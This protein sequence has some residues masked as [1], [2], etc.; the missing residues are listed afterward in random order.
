MTLS[1]PELQEH[2]SRAGVRS[3]KTNNFLRTKRDMCLALTYATSA[4]LEDKVRQVGAGRKSLD[5]AFKKQ[6]MI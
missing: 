5:A 1:V 3:S 2:L 4:A 6:K